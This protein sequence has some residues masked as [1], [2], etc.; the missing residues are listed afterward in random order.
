MSRVHFHRL[1]IGVFLLN[2][3]VR[4]S[5][6]SEPLSSDAIRYGP[7]RKQHVHLGRVEPKASSL[8]I[9]Y[10]WKNTLGRAV[11]IGRIIESCG[12]DSVVA[13]RST[14]GPGKNV[15]FTLRVD[16]TGMYG[17]GGT[18]FAVAFSQVKTAV[19]FSCTWFRERP[20]AADPPR[21]D[22]GEVGY[23]RTETR[24]FD[25][26]L[27]AEGNEAEIAAMKR[28]ITSSSDQLKCSL[29][30]HRSRHKRIPIYSHATVQHKFLFVAKYEGAKTRQG[31][32]SGTITVPFR[33]GSAVKT[34]AVPFRGRQLS[35]LRAR[36]SHLVV[37]TES[38][39]KKQV[40]TVS[41]LSDMAEKVPD[42]FLCRCTNRRVEATYDPV[43]SVRPDGILGVLTVTIDAAEGSPITSEV[44]LRSASMPSFEVC[45]PVRI[46]FVP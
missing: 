30:S 26:T 13:G 21:L 8:L 42:D 16:L 23:A 35:P 41:I 15:H 45:V 17:H 22:F 39:K 6:A 44:A 25:V 27:F 5:I 31:L 32:F 12:C 43:A 46:R 1:L 38:L 10:D 36:P 19:K 2:V 29:V 34:L 11:S 14:V 40:A 9:R 18:S 33:I 37:V 28:D 24:H 4:C 20:L 3:V 7:F